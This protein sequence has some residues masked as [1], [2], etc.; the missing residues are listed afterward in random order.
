MTKT[1]LTSYQLKIIALCTMTID[2]LAAYGGEIPIFGHYAYILRIVGRIAA[3][4]FL[5]VLTE[6]VRHTHNKIH[7]VLRLYFASRQAVSNWA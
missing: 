1:G 3:P 4:L 5:F 6:S 2:H 7:Y